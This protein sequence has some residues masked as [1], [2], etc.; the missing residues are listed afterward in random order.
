MNLEQLLIIDFKKIMERTF[1]IIK[2]QQLEIS[3][4]LAGALLL[5]TPHLSQISS[6]VKM[7]SLDKHRARKYRR[8][9]WL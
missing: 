1:S 8:S 9:S 6:R 5:N 4:S 7:K 2:D 3:K